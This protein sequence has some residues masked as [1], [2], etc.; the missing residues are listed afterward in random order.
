M[1]IKLSIDRLTANQTTE[2]NILN[3]RDECYLTVVGTTELISRDPRSGSTRRE[4]S[5]P[6]ALPRVSPPPPEDYWGLK[7]KQSARNLLI[8]EWHLELTTDLDSRPRAPPHSA[9]DRP[10]P[11][12]RCEAY[13]TWRPGE[14]ERWA[15][16]C[17]TGPVRTKLRSASQNSSVAVKRGR[18]PLPSKAYSCALGSR[19][20]I[21]SAAAK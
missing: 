18:C 9:E 4:Q 8:K 2:D 3:D 11:R 19:A 12:G 10:W 17:S 14:P 13:A 16:G 6:V 5:D 1:K 20:A 15:E 21:C 7:N